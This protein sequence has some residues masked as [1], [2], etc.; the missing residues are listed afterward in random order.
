MVKAAAATWYTSSRCDPLTTSSHATRPRKQCRTRHSH[1][2]WRY[3]KRS[4]A[5][6]SLSRRSWTMS[7][8]LSHHTAG[9]SSNGCTPTYHLRKGPTDLCAFAVP[10]NPRR[11]PV[12]CCLC[13]SDARR[14]AA[15]RTRPLTCPGG[16]S[17]ARPR[18]SPAPATPSCWRHS[19]CA[20]AG[21][22][23]VET[24]ARTA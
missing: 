7:Q 13:G 15:D 11:K 1:A 8:G 5:I 4:W 22:S 24:R 3:E 2:S 23:A 14:Y 10:S 6:R 9:K 20:R 17:A 12:P 18:P 16:A 19:A 21:T